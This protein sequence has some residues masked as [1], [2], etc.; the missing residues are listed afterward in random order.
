MTF[1]S[2]VATLAT[3]LAT[4]FN[5]L[6]AELGSAAAEDVGTSAGSVVQLDGSGRLPAVDGSQLTNLP[7]GGGGFTSTLFYALGSGSAN[8]PTS[9]A[10]V[11]LAAPQVNTLAAS[12]SSNEIT[13]PAS[14]DGKLARI[15]FAVGGS[16]ATNRCELRAEIQVDPDGA[17]GFSRVKGT[18]NYVARNGNQNTG[19]V[20][21]HHY[22]TLATGMVIRFQALRDGSTSNLRAD[23]SSLAILT[24]S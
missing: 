24:L 13:I 16:G 12:V 20:Q 11:P 14:A 5:T 21:G 22:L 10:N 9:L 4:E 15:D 17:S 7:G 6:R 1:A 19:G 18:A 3:R 8:L 23:E 2:N